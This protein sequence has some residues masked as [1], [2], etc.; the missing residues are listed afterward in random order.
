VY[1]KISQILQGKVVVS[2]T[3][4]DRSALR[5][6]CDKYGLPEIG[7]RWLDSARVTRKAWPQFAQRGYG[8]GNITSHLGIEFKH[9]DAGE[10]ARAAGMVLLKAIEETGI[11]LDG[12]FAHLKRPPD[13]R[14]DGHLGGPLSGEVI[15]FTGALSVPRRQAANIADAAGGAVGQSVT[16]KTTMLVVGSQDLERLAGHKKSAKHRKAEDLI[17]KGQPIRILGED[18]FVDLIEDS[19]RDMGL[20]VEDV[21]ILHSS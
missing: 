19:L 1:E 2:H 21:L 9:H 16:R 13:V 8:L 7:C 20:R 3:A 5:Q 10:D 12:W 17:L 6:V 14:R 15:V 4:F 18:D 11:D